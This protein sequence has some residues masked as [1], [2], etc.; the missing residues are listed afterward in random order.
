MGSVLW[1]LY[2]HFPGKLRGERERARY[3][4][5]HECQTRVSD[6]CWAVSPELGAALDELLRQRETIALLE[7]RQGFTHGVRLGMRIAGEAL[8]PWADTDQ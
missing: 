1:E 5:Y 3:A 6:R 8:A 2:E 4:A 7:T